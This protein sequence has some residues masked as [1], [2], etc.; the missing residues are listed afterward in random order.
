MEA[1]PNWSPTGW[2]WWESPQGYEGER[3]GLI[4]GK[5]IRHWKKYYSLYRHNFIDEWDLNIASPSSS[6]LAVTVLLSPL[7]PWRFSAETWNEIVKKFDRFLGCNRDE[8]ISR[9]HPK[10]LHSIAIRH[11]PRE[12]WDSPWTC[13]WSLVWDSALQAI[14]Q[15]RERSFFAAPSHQNRGGLKIKL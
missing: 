3:R 14:S 1:R 5:E 8:A 12:P 13:I 4:K 15:S 6:V 10:V 7:V 2:N 9:T 11:R